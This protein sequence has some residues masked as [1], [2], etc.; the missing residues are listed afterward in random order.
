MLERRL[1]VCTALAFVGVAP[2]AHAQQYVAPPP[3]P[4]FTLHLRRLGDGVAGFLRQVEVRRRH[5]RAVEPG[6]EPPG[7]AQ[8][9]QGQATLDTDPASTTAGAFLIGAS[10]FGAYWYPEKAFGNA[11]FRIQF[12]VQPDR[13][14]VVSTRNGGVMIRS[15]EIR[16]SCPDPANPTGPRIGCSTTNG[17]AATLA[18]KPAGFNYDLCPAAIPLCNLTAPAA[19]T[20]YTWAGASGP[21]P[22]PGTYT[23]GYCARQHRGRRLRRQRPQQQPADGQRQRRQPPALDAGLLRPRD[24]DQRVA[25]RQR[26]GSRRLGPDQDRLGLR[27]PQPQRQAVG[28]AGRI[29]RAR[30]ALGKGVWHEF[31]IRT[32]G[33]QYTILVDGEMINQFDNSIPKIASRAG[34]P[35]TMARQLAQGYL[36]LQTHGGND[37]ISYREIQVKEIAPD[38]DPGQHGRAVGHQPTPERHRL[39]GQ[40][41][42]AATT[43]RGTRPRARRTS[44]AGIARTRSRRTARACARRASSTTG[45]VTDAGRAPRYGTTALTWLDSQIVGT[46]RHVHAHVRRTSARP[47]Y[48]A[49]N[50]DAGGATVWKTAAAPEIVFAAHADTTAS[51]NVPATLSLSLGA[52]ATFGAFLPGVAGELRRQ[53]DRERDLD[54]R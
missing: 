9:G 11:V 30:R 14:G 13:G 38:D 39:H 37:R 10:P 49:A 25:D 47:M 18:L 21:F 45:N 42:D 1:A 17:N 4:G 41:A 19:S 27:L 16:Y 40:A 34:D 51:A 53:H 28:H 46:E 15:P 52:P 26:P 44:R 31:E 3:D 36:G 50:V 33:Q 43:A 24:P 23:G 6:S 7:G 2:A 5:A 20:T 8:G 22:P 54:R 35:P 29:A 48:C 32:I 12:T